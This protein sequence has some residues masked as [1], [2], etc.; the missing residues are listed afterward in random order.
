MSKRA[1][2]MLQHIFLANGYQMDYNTDVKNFD[3]LKRNSMPVLIAAASPG[4]FCMIPDQIA[5]SRTLAGAGPQTSK[6]N[7]AE[8]SKQL[9]SP[10][11]IRI[12]E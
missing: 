11:F 9:P 4:K 12:N 2:R 8:F 3:L 10:L 7:S 1:R 6:I 5:A